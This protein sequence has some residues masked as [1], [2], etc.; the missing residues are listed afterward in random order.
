MTDQIQVTEIIKPAITV[1]R[2]NGLSGD[3]QVLI[4][5]NP[6]VT[7]HYVYPWIDNAGQ[8]SIAEKIAKMFKGEE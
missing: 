8:W 3:L 2:A 7:V 4:D 1:D 6:V 5:G